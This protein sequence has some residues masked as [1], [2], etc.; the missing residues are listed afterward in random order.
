MW[1]SHLVQLSVGWHGQSIY[2]PWEMTHGKCD[3]CRHSTLK[4][5]QLISWL[6]QR[7]HL[8]CFD[9]IT[10]WPRDGSDG[11]AISERSQSKRSSLIKII[12]T[13]I[14]IWLH[15]FALQ[16]FLGATFVKNKVEKIMIRF[17]W[18][19]SNGTM[20]GILEFPIVWTF[21]GSPDI[22]REVHPGLRLAPIY[23][24]GSPVVWS[25]CDW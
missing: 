6:D 15:Q 8:D 13:W 23:T 18:V 14:S 17:C 21:S 16:P 9:T 5:N 4:A 11:F 1:L 24:M 3:A 22:W 25:V 20:V 10:Y 7:N 2:M 19:V 12:G